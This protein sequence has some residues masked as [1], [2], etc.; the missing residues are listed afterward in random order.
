[1]GKPQPVVPANTIKPPRLLWSLN[2]SPGG[3]VDI[4][5]TMRRAELI[6]DGATIDVVTAMVKHIL[7]RIIDQS[8]IDR[9]MNQGAYLYQQTGIDPT[10]NEEKWARLVAKH[11]T[12]M[13][14][15]NPDFTYGEGWEQR[16]LNTGEYPI[17][18]C[19]QH[20]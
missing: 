9:I 13:P 10:S 3:L 6:N 8:A 16:F 7:D 4:S 17:G 19:C 2:K 18:V 12:G 11:M 1:M 5:T 15:I 20:N 14:Y